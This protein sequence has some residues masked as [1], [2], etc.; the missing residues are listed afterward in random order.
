[1]ADLQRLARL[2]GIRF[3]KTQCNQDRATKLVVEGAMDT[4]QFLKQDFKSAR[5]EQ[6]RLT[7]MFMKIAAWSSADIWLCKG[8]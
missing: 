8:A 3:F 1:V 5:L 4:V 2:D 6:N 7:T